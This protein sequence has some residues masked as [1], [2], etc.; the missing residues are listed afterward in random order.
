MIN[1]H[2]LQH[3]PISEITKALGIVDEYTIDLRKLSNILDMGI[4]PYD[5]E[6]HKIDNEKIICAFVTNE[7]GRFA[8]FYD[9]KLYQQW[10]I[11]RPM[12]V[13][14]FSKYI[15]TGNKHFYITRNTF[16][17]DREKA[18]ASEMLM[19][20]PKVYEVLDRL[21][22]PTTFALSEIFEVSQ[23]FVRQRLA[24]MQVDRYIAGYNY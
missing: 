20:E 11:G 22:L 4:V 12:V 1:L 19:P 17:S 2:E 24:Q 16:F 8:I 3:K 14:T 5:F 18:L 15:L 13:L 7:N 23:E 21:L 6:E 9:D 10:S